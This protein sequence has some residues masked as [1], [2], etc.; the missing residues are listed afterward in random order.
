MRNILWIESTITCIASSVYY[1][2]NIEIDKYNLSHEN[3]L[4]WED[5]NRLRYMDWAL[6]TPLMLISLIFVLSMNSG[7]AIHLSQIVGIVILD[8]LMLF[9]GYLGEKHILDKMVADV[10]GFIP[11][12]LM[13]GFIYKMFLEGKKI[14][15]NMVIFSIYFF[16][17]IAYGVLYM[18]DEKT[19]NTVF[20]ILD[21]VSKA[22]VS[23]GLTIYLLLK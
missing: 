13:F 7:I 4:G 21:C 18:F 5:V 9:F 16:L 2:Y 17:W 15:E 23:T 12:F 8:W 20:N 3:T 14:S 10:L 1:L 19:M 6:T 11:F 22:F